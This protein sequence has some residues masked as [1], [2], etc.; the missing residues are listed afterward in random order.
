[1]CV[2]VGTER[3]LGGLGGGS[4]AWLIR[5]I[6]H[7]QTAPAQA[8]GGSPGPRGLAGLRGP[9]PRASRWE[10]SEGHFRQEVAYIALSVTGHRG[11][12][13]VGGEMLG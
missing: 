2:D 3:D 8:Q 11:L 13:P 7:E 5:P 6:I 12:A 10:G 4:R 9:L 1:M